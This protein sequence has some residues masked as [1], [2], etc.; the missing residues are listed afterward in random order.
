M[1]T[2]SAE[3][4]IGFNPYLI[5][6]VAMCTY[7]PFRNRPELNFAQICE[8]MLV[9]TIAIG[10]RTGGFRHFGIALNDKSVSG[11]YCI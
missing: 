3:N 1:S 6:F 4:R 2:R 9:V 7:I 5:P 11:K 10:S 8:I